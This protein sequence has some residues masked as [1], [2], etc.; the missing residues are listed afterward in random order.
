MCLFLA[1]GAEVAPATIQGHSSITSLSRFNRFRLLD[2]N[3][4]GLVVVVV[5]GCPDLTQKEQRISG[6]LKEH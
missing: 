1:L 2:A 3:G 6:P 4:G 5:V